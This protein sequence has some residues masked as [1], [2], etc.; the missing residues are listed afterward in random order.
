MKR[1]GPIRRRTSLSRA[2]S[3]RSPA[4]SPSTERK[5]KKRPRG[6]VTAETANDVRVRDGSCRAWSLGFALDVR[7]GGRNHI[8]H[9][10]LRSQGG[11]HEADNL[12]LLCEVHHQLAHDVRRADAE[13][14]DI[15]RR[16]R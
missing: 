2:T 4:R 9:R 14:F 10:V 15:I 5:A 7:C 11:G 1:S 13:R 12:L 3:T 8:H 6:G 16:S